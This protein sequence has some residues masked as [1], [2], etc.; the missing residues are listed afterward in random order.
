[1][2][3][4]DRIFLAHPR[5]IGEGYGEHFITALGFGWRMA[6]G[7]LACM[8]HALVPALFADTASR[9]ILTLEATMRA[10]AATRKPAPGHAMADHEFAWVI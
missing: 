7:G 2:T 6:T 5:S 3:I 9:T 4:I 8:V 1:M 10:R